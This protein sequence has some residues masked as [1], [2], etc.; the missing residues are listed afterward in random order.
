MLVFAINAYIA[1]KTSK[2][3]LRY[4]TKTIEQQTA[5]S[6]YTRI[7]RKQIEKTKGN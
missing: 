5:C 4:T 2:I 7:D 3:L 1:T 6:M